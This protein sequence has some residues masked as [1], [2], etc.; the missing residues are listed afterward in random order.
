MTGYSLYA[1][2]TLGAMLVTWGVVSMSQA[3]A[4]EGSLLYK[5]SSAVPSA[6]WRLAGALHV[7]WIGRSVSWLIHA[8]LYKRHPII[9]IL[10]V[11]IIGGSFGAFYVFGFPDR[12][13]DVGLWS[14]RNPYFAAHHINEAWVLLVASLGFFAAASFL[15][16]GV[17][18]HANVDAHLAAYP[19]DN[20]LYVA[21]G[22]KP[23]DTCKLPRPARSKHCSVC[24]HCVS[25]FDHHW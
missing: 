12:G 16:P 2:Y 1:W 25:R 22:R 9:Q 18:T 15:D 7:Q 3:L 21:Q 8:L 5:L 10:Y 13:A 6:V 11:G 23:C 20:I 17:I 14:N 19:L 4:P 24:N